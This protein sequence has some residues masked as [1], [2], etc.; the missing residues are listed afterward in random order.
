[1]EEGGWGGGG[2]GG[3]GGELSHSAVCKH[4]LPA[5]LGHFVCENDFS[6]LMLR[7]GGER[8]E[9]ER[10]GERWQDGEKERDRGRGGGG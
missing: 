10:E 5:I 8:V 9:G 6:D 4:V 2:G 7:E 1:M 3:G